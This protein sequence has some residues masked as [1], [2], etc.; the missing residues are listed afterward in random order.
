MIKESPKVIVNQK[1]T[2]S[3]NN[4][5]RKGSIGNINSKINGMID[6]YSKS[7]KRMLNIIDYYVGDINK[8]ETMNLLLENGEYATKEDLE[9]RKKEIK[10]CIK[11]SNLWQGVISFNN[12]YITE[13]IDIKKLEK[14]LML[15]IL[16]KYFKNIGFD[17]K[18]NMIFQASLHTDTDNQHFHYSFVQKKPNYKTK[19]GLTYRRKG[20]VSTKN[21]NYLKS[22]I[23][24]TIEKDKIYTPL[25]VD[26][27]LQ[28]EHLKKYFKKGE[29]NFL[30]NNK[31]DLILEY[32]ILKLS[33]LIKENN[34]G[35]NLKI[36]YNSISN[37]EIKQLVK[38]IKKGLESDISYQKELEVLQSNFNKLHN[39]FKSLDENITN[40]NL[41]K[42][43]KQYLDSYV[44]NSIINYANN[45]YKN[46][47][48]INESNL[49]K[50][51]ILKNYNAKKLK[52]STYD[53]LIDNL[54]SGGINL[55]NKNA[56]IS[57]V[58]KL[59][60]DLEDCQNEFSKLFENNYKNEK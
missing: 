19:K 26:T 7:E 41:I 32:N 11:N 39:Y 53:I 9:I 8:S 34:V 4:Q 36:K 46:V 24:H 40:D 23:M 30:L 3:I 12:D 37:N 50:F 52:T 38:S 6:Y 14:E 58:K 10:K 33:M 18:Q 59:N 13:N 20:Q 22:L 21:I 56:I 55:N 43:K 28:I 42:M 17:K 49:L 48:K 16:P 60:K 31:N 57:S 27:N 15:S 47:S 5:D 54:K 35:N 45:K 25:L 1:Y 51:L 44:S 29:K 2:L